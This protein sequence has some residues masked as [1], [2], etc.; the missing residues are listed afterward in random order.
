LQ[1][2]YKN[3][4]LEKICTNAEEAEKKHGLRM[5]EIIHERIDQITA[6]DSVGML[7]QFRIG[8]CHPLKGKRKNQYAMD[9]IHPFR[10]IFEKKGEDIQIVKIVDI[11]DYH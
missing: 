9:L 11:A 4:S 10:L 3:R 6:F 5:A 7:I 8:R 1:I 2:E